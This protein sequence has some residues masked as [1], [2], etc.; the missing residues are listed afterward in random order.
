MRNPKKNTN[1]IQFNLVQFV[2]N[3]LGKEDKSQSLS[4]V[5]D[6]VELLGYQ[7]KDGIINI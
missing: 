5:F 3:W 4:M 6:L 7:V 2:E 1:K